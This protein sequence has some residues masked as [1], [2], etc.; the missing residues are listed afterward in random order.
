MTTATAVATPATSSRPWPAAAPIPAAAN[1][2]AAVVSPLHLL[3]ANCLP[4][5]QPAADEAD[6]GDRPGQG[7]GHAMRRDNAQHPAAHPDQ[8][9]HPVPGCRAALL[10]LEPQRIGE[11]ERHHQ[12][13]RICRA[14]SHCPT[15]LAS[16]SPRPPA[17]AASDSGTPPAAPPS[18]GAPATA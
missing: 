8:G 1:N 6:P 16:V 11:R 14:R 15:R 17:G 3:A 13:D 4:E 2:A 5:H 10:P 18:G 9:E 7:G 12:V